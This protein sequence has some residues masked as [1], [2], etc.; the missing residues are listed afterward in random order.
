MIR[1]EKTYLKTWAPYL[2]CEEIS[3]QSKQVHDNPNLQFF[4]H[5][6]CLLNIQNMFLKNFCQKNF[7]KT[8]YDTF[9]KNF[10][11]RKMCLFFC[12]EANLLH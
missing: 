9:S 3:D 6:P 5:C 11:K 4:L 1:E 12:V 10:L 8:K 7:K 2:I